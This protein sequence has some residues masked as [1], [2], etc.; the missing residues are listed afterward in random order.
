MAKKKILVTGVAGFI[1][2]NLADRLLSGGH[3]V[4]G[5]DNLSYGVFEQIPKGVY[6]HKLDIRSKDI[7]PL[8]NGVDVVFHLAAKNCIEDCQEDPVET[9]DINVMGTANVFEAARRAK[10]RK[11]VNAESSAVYE[12]IDVF[13]TPESN[14]APHS[15]YA[16]SKVCGNLFA[17]KYAEFHGVIST[18]IRPFSVYGSKQDYRRTIPPSMPAFIIKLLMGEQPIIYGDGSKRRDFLYIEDFNDF[19][20]L[21]VTDPRTDGKIF[22]LGSGTNNSIL[23]I[24]NIVKKLL[25]S[26]V[27]PIFKPNLSGEAQITL[28]DMSEAKKLGWS[29]K[30]SIEEG[31]RVLAD[32]LKKEKELGRLK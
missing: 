1:G 11:V 32:F 9:A 14:I 23:E 7:Y 30:I 13:P 29:P 2:S 3:E 24:Y 12:G 16:T 17:E 8:F 5:I 25:V 21:C 6:F 10:V 4:V 22:N 19:L 27:E 15:F 31:I 18:G 20:M 26:N 28:A